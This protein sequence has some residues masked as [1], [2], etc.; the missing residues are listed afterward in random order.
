[1]I[2]NPERT[3]LV[4]S[5]GWVDHDFLW[6]YDVRAST[7]ER[8]SLG[9]GARYLSLHSSG[10]GHFSALHHFDG[11]R[12]ELTVHRFSDPRDILARA[13]VNSKERKLDGD[14]AAWKDVPLLYVDYL[15]FAPW[16]DFVLLKIAPST[17]RIDVQRLEWYDETFDKGYQGVID[18]LEL[19]GEDSALVSVQ[20]S[21][22]LVLHD[23]ETGT[24]KGSIDLGGRGGNPKLQLRKSGSEIWASDYDTLVVIQRE[25]WR[26]IRSARLQGAGAAAQQFIG[27]FSF[28]PD[29]DS[30]VVA[31]PF[32]GDV[33][34]IDAV[35]LKIKRA[36]RLGRQPLEVIAL[37]H[38][39]VVAR[40][41]KTGDMLHGRLER[42][43]FVR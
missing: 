26:I 32:S 14:G 27:D 42:R 35:T 13:S 4:S 31:R 18:V 30:C 25:D 41:W 38:G 5:V 17:G 1:M 28:A 23:L 20:R 34:G 15:D 29:G 39:E 2:S 9:T 24:K 12:L 11:A 8:I 37:P 7:A 3:V 33:V 10:A 6:R 19:P 21:S 43:W 36:A 16:K 22:Q 40:D